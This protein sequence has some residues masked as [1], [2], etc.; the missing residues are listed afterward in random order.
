M[1]G[2]V[3]SASLCSKL[4]RCLPCITLPPMTLH[5]DLSAAQSVQTSRFPEMPFL[6]SEAWS[7][8]LQVAPYPKL[9]VLLLG[10]TS[11]AIGKG[12]GPDF[13]VIEKVVWH[14]SRD[15]TQRESSSW[16]VGYVLQCTMGT[17]R[18]G[19]RS[20]MMDLAGLCP[21]RSGSCPI[22]QSQLASKVAGMGKSRPD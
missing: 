17:D 20:G 8:L 16:K 1:L 4:L 13:S 21:W 11:G 3:P 9:L 15:M 19:G 2:C 18:Q 22:S 7:T 5:S 10:R 12:C 6:V 14:P